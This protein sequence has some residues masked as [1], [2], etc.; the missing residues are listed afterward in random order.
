MTEQGS[1]SNPLAPKELSNINSFKCDSDDT[2]GDL[3]TS[4]GELVAASE[5]E[6]VEEWDF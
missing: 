6:E 4:S 1:F 2:D 3:Q 5:D